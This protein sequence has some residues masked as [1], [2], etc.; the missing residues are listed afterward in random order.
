MLIQ[1]KLGCEMAKGKMPISLAEFSRPGL[2]LTQ[3]S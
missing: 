3:A 1:R 2:H